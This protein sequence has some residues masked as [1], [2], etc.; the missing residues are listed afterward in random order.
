MVP[1]RRRMAATPWAATAEAK[2]K[3]KT[4]KRKADDGAGTGPMDAF[5]QAASAPK[6][7]AL[8]AVAGAT[9]VAGGGVGPK[10]A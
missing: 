9:K 8:A 1:T 5:V 3:A 2:G 10:P 7:P 4:G 6:R